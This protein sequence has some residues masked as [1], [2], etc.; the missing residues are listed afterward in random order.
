MHFRLNV[1]FQNVYLCRWHAFRLRTP[2]Y[3]FTEIKICNIS[4]WSECLRSYRFS[5]AAEHKEHTDMNKRHMM[6]V[7][8]RRKKKLAKKCECFALAIRFVFWLRLRKRISYSCKNVIFFE[9]RM[10]FSQTGRWRKG[11]RNDCLS[12]TNQTPTFGHQIKD[13]KK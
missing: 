3:V 10:A 9:R 12:R 6:N 7:F 2:R 1:L 4:V 11:Q 5:L 13:K 8:L